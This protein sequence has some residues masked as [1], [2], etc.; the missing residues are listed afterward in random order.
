MLAEHA[1]LGKFRLRGRWRAA[2]LLFTENETNIERL[3]GV[4]DA[5]ALTSRTPSTST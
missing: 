2:E 1:S 5:S 4:Q 3:F